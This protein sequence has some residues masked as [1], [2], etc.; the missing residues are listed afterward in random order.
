M[1]LLKNVRRACLISPSPVSADSNREACGFL[2]VTLTILSSSFLG[3]CM[4]WCNSLMSNT[5]LLRNFHRGTYWG[6]M[7]V[8][9]VW[10]GSKRRFIFRDFA[11]WFIVLMKC[12]WLSHNPQCNSHYS[13]VHRV[14]DP[15]NNHPI[16]CIIHCSNN[17]W[18][19][20]GRPHPLPLYFNSPP[21]FLSKLVFGSAV[22]E[23]W[24]KEFPCL[25]LIYR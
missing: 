24:D 6:K 18:W 23:N 3:D 9:V 14:P 2:S 20:Y 13:I 17:A 21:L 1:S 4:A 19:V 10:G 25:Y 7:V 12:V 8:V 15:C 11:Q 16:P 22:G 5:H